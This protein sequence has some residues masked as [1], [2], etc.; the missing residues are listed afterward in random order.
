MRKLI[1]IYISLSIPAYKTGGIINSMRMHSHISRHQNKELIKNSRQIKKSPR[2]HI[3]HKRLFVLS[4]TFGIGPLVYSMD[5][6]LFV[7]E[8]DS[9][10]TCAST[11]F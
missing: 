11:E 2:L 8:Q 5:T 10:R 3:L 9:R 7:G 6:S 1:L 4:K